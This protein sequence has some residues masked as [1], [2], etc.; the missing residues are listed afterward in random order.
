MPMAKKR[1]VLSRPILITVISGV[2]PDKGDLNNSMAA[3]IGFMA[4]K[5]LSHCCCIENKG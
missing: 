3:F 4:S 1:K 2:V 5:Y